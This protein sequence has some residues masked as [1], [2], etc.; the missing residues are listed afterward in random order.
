M[1][2]A[3]LYQRE[4]L[5]SS[6]KSALLEAGVSIALERTLSNLKLAD[7][8]AA[9]VNGIVVNLDPGIEEQIEVI[10]FLFADSRLPLVFNDPTVSNGL[11]GWDRARWARHLAAKVYGHADVDP[12]RPVSISDESLDFALRAI[13]ELS[14]QP[15]RGAALSR[16]F[17]LGASIGGP[18]A[19]RTFLSLLPTPTPAG[20]VLAQH[21]GAEFLDLMVQQL[22]RATPLSVRMARHG[23]MLC[24]GDVVVV[25]VDLALSI[26]LNG[27][28]S[29]S[30]LTEKTPY[31]PS[32]DLVMRE[33]SRVHGA[34]AGAIVF[35][36]MAADGI[37]G[38]VAI[39][40]AGGVVW[41]QDP[42]SCVVSS[43]V[44]G[45]R[46]RGVVSFIATPEGLA[47][48]F[49]ARYATAAAELVGSA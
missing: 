40:H 28:I 18:E 5:G 20:F 7:L 1:K 19:L 15:A 42:D 23:D 29:L 12:P 31:S 8:D 43:I 39:A 2:V 10:D 44:D 45:A 14:A 17:V 4:E 41:A 24:D 34:A 22:D 32:I 13:E 21:M 46:S 30:A 48:A 6:L 37:E 25:P 38:A 35:S 27:R 9:G 26:D 33:I 47:E 3:L 49:V 11:T 16:I 36:G